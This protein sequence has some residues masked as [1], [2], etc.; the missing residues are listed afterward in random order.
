[1]PVFVTGTDT[2]A[3]KTL[4]SSWLCSHTGAAYWKPFQTGIAETADSDREMVKRLTSVRLHPEA[5]RF[6]NPLSPQAAAAAEGVNIDVD[7]IVLP[8]ENRLIIEGAGGVLVPLTRDVLLIDLIQKWCFPVI[9]VARSTLGTINHTCLT[10]EAL[11]RRNIPVLG[12]IM[13]GPPNA[14]NRQAIE[15]FGRVCVLAEF[16]FLATLSPKALATLV[17]PDTLKA[18]LDS[19]L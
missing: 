5:Y 14:S 17:L 6:R 9:V 19:V 16:P 4:I 8:V 3:G 11:E 15:N 7:N 12:V 13:N 2:N 1:M 18:A 10:L